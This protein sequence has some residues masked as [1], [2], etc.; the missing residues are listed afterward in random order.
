MLARPDLE[1]WPAQVQLRE[2]LH[3][4]PVQNLRL[5]PP[6]PLLAL[7]SPALSPQAKANNLVGAPAQRLRGEVY[8]RACQGPSG[9]L[10][11]SQL[12]S[13]ISLA[14]MGFIIARPP[15]S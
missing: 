7:L 2:I 13:I 1:G 14:R 9:P 5:L 4:F 15:G 11:W 8:A 6:P 12:V 10:G 3:V